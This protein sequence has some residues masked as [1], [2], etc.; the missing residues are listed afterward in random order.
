[1]NA[2]DAKKENMKNSIKLYKLDENQWKQLTGGAAYEANAV[3][4]GDECKRT[5]Y[6]DGRVLLRE[7]R[8]SRGRRLGGYVP[9]WPYMTLEK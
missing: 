4:T 6:N 8:D 9:A 3:F 1:M 7:V 2:L 5:P